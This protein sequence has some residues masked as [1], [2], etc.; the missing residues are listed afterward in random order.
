MVSAIVGVSAVADL[1]AVVNIPSIGDSISSNGVLLLPENSDV[2]VLSIVVVSPAASV[3]LTAVDVPGIL[4]LARIFAVTVV[5]TAVENLE[6]WLWIDSVLMLP[7]LLLLTFLLLLKVPKFL[8]SLLLLVY[9]LLLAS[10]LLLT[11]YFPRFWHPCCV[12]HS[13]MFQLPLC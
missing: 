11:F 13:L 10:L 6:F 9:L 1:P 3:V 12:W 2:P 7:S 8:A 5:P 4:A